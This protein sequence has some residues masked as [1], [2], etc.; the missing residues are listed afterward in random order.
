M[1]DWRKHQAECGAGERMYAHSE[2][3]RNFTSKAFHKSTATP[4][5][6]PR[7]WSYGDR[8]SEPLG[9]QVQGFCCPFQQRP[10]FGRVTDSAKPQS[11]GGGRRLILLS[12]VKGRLEIRARAASRVRTGSSAEVT[13]EDKV[14]TERVHRGP[15]SET[16][17]TPTHPCGNEWQAHQ[18]QP[19]APKVPVLHLYLPSSLYEDEEQDAEAEEMRPSAERTDVPPSTG[20]SPEFPQ[21]SDL[22][23]DSREQLNTAVHS[24]PQTPSDD[25]TL[26]D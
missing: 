10:N 7:P 12:E 11:R 4:L 3:R 26:E 23:V 14:P 5:L 18:T 17:E 19:G 9:L 15:L 25:I 13:P 1:T 2:Q 24:A 6:P 22:P 20:G 16:A 8:G 21:D